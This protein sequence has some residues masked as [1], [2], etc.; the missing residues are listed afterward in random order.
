MPPI[1]SD[2]RRRAV[3][4][5]L[6]VTLGGSAALGACG[7]TEINDP[8]PGDTGSDTATDAGSDTAPTPDTTPAPDTAPDTEPPPDI[9]LDTM[10]DTGPLPGEECSA[11]RDGICPEGCT[12]DNDADCCEQ[13][14]S[15]FEWCTWDPGF[16]CGCAVEGPFAPPSLGAPR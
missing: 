6:A 5:A 10:V 3:Y 9:G 2:A 12:Q 16:G 15:D 7:S 14:N 11:E 4:A 8:E 13:V 1:K